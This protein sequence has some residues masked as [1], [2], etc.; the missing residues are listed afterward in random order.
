MVLQFSVHSPTSLASSHPRWM[1]SS[2]KRLANSE[3]SFFSVARVSPCECVRVRV[4]CGWVGQRISKSCC[5]ALFLYIHSKHAYTHTLPHTRASMKNISTTYLAGMHCKQDLS[6]ALPCLADVG[7]EGH[8][9]DTT[10]MLSSVRRL[11]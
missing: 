8:L 10:C 4:E 7:Q 11:L 9:V 2:G 3:T 1:N 6:M 5:Q